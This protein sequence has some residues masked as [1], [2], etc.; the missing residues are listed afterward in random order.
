M[1]NPNRSGSRGQQDT[2]CL[3]AEHMGRDGGGILEGLGSW[4]RH[5]EAAVKTMVTVESNES[6]RRSEIID[7]MPRTRASPSTIL[8]FLLSPPMSSAEREFC[9]DTVDRRVSPWSMS[10]GYLHLLLELVGRYWTWGDEREDNKVDN[11]G[12]ER[13][14]SLLYGMALT[15]LSLDFY[16]LRL[17]SIPSVTQRFG[18]SIQLTSHYDCIPRPRTPIALELVR[19]S[20]SRE[21]WESSH[22]NFDDAATAAFKFEPRHSE[23]KLQF[24]RIPEPWFERFKPSAEPFEPWPWLEPFEPKKSKL[25]ELF[26]PKEFKFNRKLCYAPKPR[27]C[28]L[29]TLICTQS[30]LD[31]VGQVQ[32]SRG[33]VA[34]AQGI[35]LGNIQN[36]YNYEAVKMCVVNRRIRNRV[37][38]IRKKH[39]AYIDRHS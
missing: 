15:K 24:E 32:L 17:L 7:D 39:T 1:L 12:G 16:T 13:Y 25:N 37:N 29:Y 19:R 26:E 6:R 4:M 20:F 14:V 30:L 18:I 8:S 9:W 10:S 27:L 35:D 2:E 11:Q 22:T 3:G 5:S 21:R 33:L 34:N 36:K 28:P 23:C 38:F 31:F